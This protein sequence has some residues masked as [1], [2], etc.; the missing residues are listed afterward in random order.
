VT[1]LDWLAIALYF[2][3]M[4]AV[5]IIIRRRVHSARDFFTAGGKMPWWL[6]GIS[7]HMSGYSSAVFV[8]Y[9]AIA[10]TDGFSLYVWWACTI[11]V[12]LLVGSKVF[13][14]RWVRL[15]LHTGMIS[16]LEYLAQRYG[17]K[18]QLCLACS[19]S[20]LKIFDV[21]AKWTASALLLQM[22]AHVPLAW[23]VLLTGGV[24]LVYSVMGGLWADAATDLSQ[25]VIQ[26][27]S[28]LAMFIVVLQRL[29]GT[30]ALTGMWYRLPADHHHLF[31]GRYTLGFAAAYLMINFLSYNG[32]T[33]SL[34]QR[35][36][37]SPD[38][39]SATRSAQLSAALYLVWPLVLFYPMWAAPLLLPHI[40]N[41]SHSY[42]TMAQ[43]FLPSGLVGLV[44]AG[45]FAHSM[46]M[47]SSDANAIAAVVV[48]DIAPVL[49][50]EG[51]LAGEK[52]QLSAARLCTL[53][54]LAGSMVIALFANRMGGVLGLILL[55]YGALVGPIAVPMLLGMLPAFKRCDAYAAMASW[56]AGI[57]TFALTKA[58]APSSFDSDSGSLVFSIGGPVLISFL[59]YISVGFMRPANNPRADKLLEAIR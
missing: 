11:V 44:L 42:A 50:P 31:H 9:A 7:H 1:F 45:L 48:R 56:L 51:W 47:T 21:G 37:A 41:P 40:S 49:L 57:A 30:S 18:T 19:G 33:W 2:L 35:F 59:T 6:S 43:L 13:A 23:G 27:I 24:T 15:R 22:F 28:G 8:G 55:W 25:F 52:R 14:P 12:A 39:R 3:L 29:G 46:A 5:G 32:G 36:L 58:F 38:E 53:L 26:L 20:L 34:A 4:L 17:V 16:P 54:F 10:Y